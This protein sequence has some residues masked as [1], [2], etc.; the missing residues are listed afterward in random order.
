MNLSAI[1]PIANFKIKLKEKKRKKSLPTY[2]NIYAYMYI[3]KTRINSTK[4]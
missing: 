2:P 4:S 3:Y 1:K